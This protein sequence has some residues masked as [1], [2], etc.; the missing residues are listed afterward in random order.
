MRALLVH[1]PTPATYW[2]FQ[3]S[4]PIAG[5]A[6][7]LP[8]LGLLSLAALLP[9]NWQIRV[10]DENVAEMSNEDLRWADAVLVTG[11]L[12]HANGIRRVLARAKAAG[13]R[14][15]VGGPAVN[16]DPGAFPEADHVFRGEAE[17]RLGQM[18]AALEAVAGDVERP[19]GTDR[20]AEDEADRRD[21]R[22]P[23]VPARRI[24]PEV[25]ARG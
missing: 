3:H 7:S 10:V 6:A 8:P 14:T 15:V 22:H 20:S 9:Q 5:K 13:K 16:T 23:E 11:M 4:L 24:V 25:I 21:V 2:G 18:I 17:G 19:I 12:I 1:P